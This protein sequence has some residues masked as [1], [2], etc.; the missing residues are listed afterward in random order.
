MNKHMTKQLIPRRSG[1]NYKPEYINNTPKCHATGTGD[2]TTEPTCSMFSHS[3]N[4]IQP[5]QADHY[6]LQGNN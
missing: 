6:K 5:H 1:V 4:T 2:C 3:I